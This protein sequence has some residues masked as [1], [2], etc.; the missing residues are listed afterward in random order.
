MLSATTSGATLADTIKFCP[1]PPQVLALA[2]PASVT[3][4]IT[5]ADIDYSLMDGRGPPTFRIRGK[6]YHKIGSIMPQPGLA[7]KSNQIYIHQSNSEELDRRMSIFDGMRRKILSHLQSTLH[8]INPYGRQMLQQEAL[9][10]TW[11]SELTQ[12]MWTS[13]GTTCLLQLVR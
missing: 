2:H 11:S 8:D 10:W 3:A 13:G 7:P 12:E 1:W 4:C 9:P 6:V 5:G